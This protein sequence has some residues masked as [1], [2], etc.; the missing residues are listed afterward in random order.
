MKPLVLRRAGSGRHIAIE[1]HDV[2]GANIVAV[3]PKTRRACDRAEVGIVGDGRR[4]VVLVVARRWAR[5]SLVASPRHVVAVT[6]LVSGAGFVRVIAGR[7]DHAADR[8]QKSRR[9]F[10]PR[11]AALRDVAGA[12]EHAADRTPRQ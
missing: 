11:V 10:G 9:F 5:P 7:E 8:I 12:D 1:R 4:R 3:V 6:V 2:P